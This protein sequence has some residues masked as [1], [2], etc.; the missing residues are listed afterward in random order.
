MYMRLHTHTPDLRQPDIELGE[1]RRLL[2]TFLFVI[3]TAETAAH[4]CGDFVIMAPGT[5]GPHHLQLQSAG[6]SEAA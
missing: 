3:G 1:F 2:K 4:W 5:S 6:Y